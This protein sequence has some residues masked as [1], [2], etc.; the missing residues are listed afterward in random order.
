MTKLNGIDRINT[1]V[2]ISGT[3][4]NLKKLIKF[5]QKKNS[6]FKISLIISN[7]YRAKGLKYSNIFKIKKKI[8]KFD[9]SKNEE[10]LLIKE[11]KKNKIKIICLAGFMRILPKSFIK[12]FKGIIL[13]IHPSLLP[14]FKG[15]N[16]HARAIK[17]KEKYSGC[18]VHIV[19]SKLD[20]GKI[21]LQKKIRVLKKDT[22]K[23]LAKRVLKQE[24]IIYPKALNKIAV[25]L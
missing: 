11:L 9:S 17:N 19:N 6:K 1:A 2:F 13:N 16:T 5:S 24:H 12:S 10:K 8:Y 4:S 22:P 14:K 18:T 3:G 23:T 7:N 15:L 25:N 21:I 20:S